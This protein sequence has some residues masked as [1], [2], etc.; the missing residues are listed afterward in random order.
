MAGTHTGGSSTHQPVSG[1]V[2]PGQTTTTG[3]IYSTG[4]GTGHTGAMTTGQKISS[5]I[6]GTE[7][8]WQKKVAKGKI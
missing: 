2:A 5:L 7:A 4:P 1:A 6:P 3:S 8:N